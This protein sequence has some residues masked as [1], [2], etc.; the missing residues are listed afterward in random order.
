MRIIGGY[1]KGKNLYFEKKHKTRPTKNIVREAI[2]DILCNEIRN[3]KILDIFA[4]TGAIGIEGLSR[5]AD[6]A[7]FVENSIESLEILK[8][9][10]HSL[11]LE[12]KTRIIFSSSERAIK[13]FSKNGESFDIIFADPPYYYEGKK[14]GKIFKFS[15]GCVKYGSIMMI[16]TFYK[17]K[18]PEESNNWQIVKEKKYST[19]KISIYQY[20]NNRNTLVRENA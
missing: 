10:V 8:K 19:T 6:F 15:E 3:K 12:D 7:V 4:G 1:L 9:N 14:L 13:N 18:M 20:I 16:E 17:L 2:F 5:G 11:G